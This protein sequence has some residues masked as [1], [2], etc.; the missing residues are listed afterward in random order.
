MSCDEKVKVRHGPRVCPLMR[1]GVVVGET[2]IPFRTNVPGWEYEDC[3]REDCQWWGLCSMFE[4]MEVGDV[5][6]SD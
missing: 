2:T 1:L 6:D 4:E 5:P 3:I